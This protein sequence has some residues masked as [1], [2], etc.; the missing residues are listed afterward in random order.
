M[1]LTRTISLLGDTDTQVKAQIKLA[2]ILEGKYKAKNVK[3][4]CQ[5]IPVGD[6]TVYSHIVQFDISKKHLNKFIKDFDLI[7]VEL[8]N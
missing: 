8:Y 3:K 2:S 5:V 7:K 4:I 6:N 1:L